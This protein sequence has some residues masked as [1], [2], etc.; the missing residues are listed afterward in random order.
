MLPGEIVEHEA[1]V[2]RALQR[3]PAV[4]PSEFTFVQWGHAGRPTNE[5]LG[6]LPVHGVEPDAVIAAV[7]AFASDLPPIAAM[8]SAAVSV[9]TS[10]TLS[11]AP[12]R[13]SAIFFSPSAAFAA[14]SASALAVAASRSALISA[15]A[16]ATMAC[17]S[18]RASARALL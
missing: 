5:G 15:L 6:V 11:S 10:L 14:I 17:A 18:A 8:T 16:S 12:A 13:I 7:M 3:I 4:P 9:A 1:F 2:E